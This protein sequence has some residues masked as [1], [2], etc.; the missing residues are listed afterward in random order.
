[1]RRC[2]ELSPDE[3]L[4]QHTTWLL[5]MAE[6]CP[7]A[8]LSPVLCCGRVYSFALN[9]CFP[10]ADILVERSEGVGGRHYKY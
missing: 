4:L 8:F 1:M 10:E 9:S 5:S 7:F 2:A 6:L 3:D